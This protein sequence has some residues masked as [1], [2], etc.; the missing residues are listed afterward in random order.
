M[1]RGAHLLQSGRA[2]LDGDVLELPVPLR[3]EVTDHVRVLVRLSQQLDLA[4]GE[5]E[6][7]GE[8][9]LDGHVAVVKHAPAG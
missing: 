5:T 4:V 1:T 7:L 6:T 2:Q 3:A 8:D 9:P